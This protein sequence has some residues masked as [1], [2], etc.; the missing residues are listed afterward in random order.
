MRLQDQVI[1][2]TG[3]TTGIGAAMARL[4]VAEGAKVILHGRNLERANALREEIGLVNTDFIQGDL[5]NPEAPAQIAKDALACFGRIDGLVNNAAFTT[6][7][8]LAD[9]DVA[10]FD[11]IISVNLRAPLQLIR[12]LMPALE[13]SEGCVVNIGSVLAHCGQ[14]NMLAYSISK[15]GLMTM[16]R[17]LADAH[18]P[19]KVRFNQLNVGWTLTENE[20]Q[21]KQDDGLPANWPE[22]LPAYAAPSGQL[23]TPEQIAEAAL[24]WASKSSR[25]ITG[26]VL[27]LE[28]YPLIGRYTN[29]ESS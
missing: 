23:I 3:S 24:Y 15:G 1:L 12:A 17:N 14:A 28:Q 13:K 18:G 4:F 29:H 27:E 19:K 26:S 8:H 10:F 16:T 11:R 6:R 25:P 21:V 9:T 2:I 22:T 5:Q 20:Y 7:A